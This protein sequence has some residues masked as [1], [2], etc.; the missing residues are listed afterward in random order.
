MDRRVFYACPA[1]LRR[2]PIT[3]VARIATA[4]SYISMEVLLGYS[5]GDM[6]TPYLPC[7]YAVPAASVEYRSTNWPYVIILRN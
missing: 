7:T 2:V 4:C 1:S 6:A 5:I 3:V